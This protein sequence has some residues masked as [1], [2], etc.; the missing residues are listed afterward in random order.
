MLMAYG[1]LQL[2]YGNLRGVFQPL[3]YL[4][5]SRKRTTTTEITT[6]CF[7]D[8]IFSANIQRSSGTISD[9][10]RHVMGR[11]RPSSLGTVAC[12]PC[13]PLSKLGSTSQTEL[14]SYRA[15]PGIYTSAGVYCL[16]LA[17]SSSTHE[18]GRPC[19]SKQRGGVEARLRWCVCLNSNIHWH[20][21]LTS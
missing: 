12:A 11:R 3:L 17:L 5:R 9:V 14:S 15:F 19:A 1:V 16:R 8:R 4:G 13:S 6:P 18:K 10:N 7:T 21:Q 2:T 20:C